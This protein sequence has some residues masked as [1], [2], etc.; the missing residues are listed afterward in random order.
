MNLPMRMA[1]PFSV[2]RLER[3][4]DK[5]LANDLVVDVALL[6]M[7]HDFPNLG[8][9]SVV[10]TVACIAGMLAPVLEPAG[11]AVRVV[12]FPVRNKLLVPEPGDEQFRI[13][14]GTGGPG[15]IDP[16]RNDGAA[17]WAQGVKEDPT[18][19]PRFQKLMD[20]VRADDRRAMV[21]ICHSFGLV[22][23]WAKVAKP[24]LR[25]PEKGGKSSGI[26]ENI[27][28]EEALAHPWFSRMAAELPDGRH[29]KIADSRLFDL[30]PFDRKHFPAGVTP[31]GFEAKGDGTESDALTMI[32]LAR[33]RA[34]VMPR[35]LAVNH[36]PEIYDLELQREL[37]AEKLARGEVSQ[38]WYDERHD[39]IG[40]LLS[41]EA[42]RHLVLTSRYTLIA[43]LAFHIFRQVRERREA[44]G[45]PG[46]LHEDQVMA[47][48]FV[49]ERRRV[50]RGPNIDGYA[51]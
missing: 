18:W 12:S 8:H 9:D 7:N 13:L 23:R 47:R 32:E 6:D 34:G 50:P 2:V 31:I 22:C 17:S 24:T 14:V 19:E 39:T 35:M 5:P 48:D 36:H 46:G 30:I 26:R 21:A 51:V 42:V 10:Q 41:P 33:D 15:H 3:A 20:R 16:D 1:Q 45:L 27:L 44:M 28:T 43:P 29:L 11:M 40:E 25:G 38:Q 37:M 4:E 49:A